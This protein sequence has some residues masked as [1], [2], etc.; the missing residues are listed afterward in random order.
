MAACVPIFSAKLLIKISNN[1]LDELLLTALI[2]LVL[3]LSVNI[4]RFFHQKLSNKFFFKVLLNL[5]CDLARETLN[6]SVDEIDKNSSGVF[7]DRLNKDTAK[8]ANVFISVSSSLSNFFA[9][10]GILVAIFFLN[11]IIFLYYLSG[12]I[13][14]FL[15]EK[16]RMK[17]YFEINKELRK[18][19]EKNTGLIS[20]LVRGIRDIKVLNINGSFLNTVY[21]RLD[22][23]NKKE[24]E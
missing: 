10:V 4:F 9:N 3:E 16:Y 2:I 6:L 20:E 19:T 14:L 7:I 22:E 5:K 18:I 23:S 13:L 17:K 15:L 24:Y 8:I 1:L 11:K 21:N 12:V